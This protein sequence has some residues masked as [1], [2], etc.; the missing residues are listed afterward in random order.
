M[1]ISASLIA[2]AIAFLISVGITPL[3]IKLA[4]KLNIVVKPG[5]RRIHDHTMPLMGG[6]GIYLGI[7]VTNL[8][9]MAYFFFIRKDAINTVF[10]NQIIG[11]LVGATFISI[12]GIIDDKFEL[13]G[14]V[15]LL[16]MLIAGFIL[17][18]FNVRVTY[19]SNP[20]SNSVN[21]IVTPVF[22]GIAITV[23]WTT[24]VT[25]AVD[26][27]DGMDGLCAGFAV[28][29]GITFLIM[30]IAKTRSHQVNPFMVTLTA[31]LA[32]ASLGFLVYNFSPA[33][34][35]MGTIGSQLI[36]FILASISILG[37]YKFTVIGILAPLLIL[38][39]PV[40]DTTYV[41]FKRVSEGRS[42]DDADKTHIHHRLQKTGRS[43]RNVVLT[44]YLLTVILC[45]IALYIFFTGK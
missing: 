1:I 39:I 14:K 3:V 4:L 45:L 37:S 42:I 32:G 29:T 19:L 12:M 20:F 15:Q 8:L 40:F 31:S 23:V 35:F 30:A 9:I 44:I 26:C 13:N 28:I 36:G 6:I 16:C 11:V 5:G 24:M 41:V 18:I 38:G 17:A 10:L 2:F 21:M 22:W 34:I 7:M 27:I 43:V 25:K 33:K